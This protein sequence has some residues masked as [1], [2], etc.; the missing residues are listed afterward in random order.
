MSLASGGVRN[1]DFGLAVAMDQVRD[2]WL[3]S[4]TPAYT[5][6]RRTARSD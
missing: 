1:T 6:P 5:S 3:M 2:A 4:G